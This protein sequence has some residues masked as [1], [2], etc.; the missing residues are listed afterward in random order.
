MVKDL[1]HSKDRT[2]DLGAVKINNDAI[3]T[4]ASLAAMEIKGVSRMGGGIG[5]TL[6]EVI[7]RRASS[8]GVRIDSHEGDV[9]LTVSIVVDYGADIPGIADE[10][11]EKVKRAV[12]RMTGLTL[13]DI[14]VIIEGVYAPAM[15][16]A[17]SC[18]PKGGKS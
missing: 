14:D 9:K 2:T 18:A 7:L 12:E 3:A 5:K 11:Q 13:A 6:R 15:D 10:V 4:I 16:D 8:K 17:K 1:S